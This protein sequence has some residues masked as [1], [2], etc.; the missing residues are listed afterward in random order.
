MT[1]GRFLTSDGL[2]L[3]YVSGTLAGFWT[4]SHARALNIADWHLHF[5][6]DHLTGGGHLLDC[7]AVGLHTFALRLALGSLRLLGRRL[8]GGLCGRGAGRLLAAASSA[9]A[10]AACGRPRLG[11]IGCVCRALGGGGNYEWLG[12]S[13]DGS[14]CCLVGLLLASTE[15]GQAET[16]SLERATAAPTDL[17]HAPIVTSVIDSPTGGILSSM[18]IGVLRTTA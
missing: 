11:G 14:C 18:G 16:P 17:R 12:L 13:L 10:A 9:A 4:P 6:T 2:V 1:S 3:T 8:L 7:R 15:P 5:V